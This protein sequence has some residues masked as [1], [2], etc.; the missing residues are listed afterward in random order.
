M[1]IT[2]DDA[3]EEE[4]FIGPIN[5]RESTWLWVALLKRQMPMQEER[6][7][8]L[9]SRREHI[10]SQLL[11]LPNPHAAKAE[12]MGEMRSHI[13]PSGELD[14]IQ[15]DSRLLTW[16]EWRLSK[17]SSYSGF[18]LPAQL[19]LKDRLIAAIDTA[20][21]GL[22]LKK[23]TMAQLRGEWS[24]LLTDKSWEIWCQESKAEKAWFAWT[25]LNRQK[26]AWGR[27]APTSDN[28]VFT[29]VLSAFDCSNYTTK[30]KA[31]F[32]EKIKRGWSQ[33]KYQEKQKKEG[34]KQYNF[35]LNQDTNEKIHRL[36]EELGIHRNQLIQLLVDGE[37]KERYYSSKHPP[38]SI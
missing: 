16:L 14:W 11:T 1:G 32:L 20:E 24:T 28:D 7:G 2:R 37:F 10:G 15:D 19:P 22:Q 3:P 36:S 21:T 9:F 33:H 13:V 23:A 6:F 30:E 34:K 35:S 12:L 31:Y 27:K 17:E 38:H 25:W 29:C 4:R 8:T 26:M 18:H 5:H